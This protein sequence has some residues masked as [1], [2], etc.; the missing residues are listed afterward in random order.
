MNKCASR[1][2]FFFFGQRK[3]GKTVKLSLN[4]WKKNNVKLEFYT[5]QNVSFKNEGEMLFPVI[6]AQKIVHPLICT[7]EHVKESLL[8]KN[9]WYW[10]EIQIYTS[11]EHYKW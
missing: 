6:I 8:D 10:V 1:F 11:N 9:K 5:A 3:S 4:Y 7:I 2:F